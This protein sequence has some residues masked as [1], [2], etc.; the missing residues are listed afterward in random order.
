VLILSMHAEDQYALRVLRENAS[1]YLVKESVPDEVIRAI[2]KAARG[3]IYV[4]DA[5]AAGLVSERTSTLD[6]PA[7]EALSSREYEIFQ[8]LASGTPIKEIAFQLALA[9]TTVATYRSR[10]LKKLR[11]KSN[12]DLVRYA[13][14]HRLVS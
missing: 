3:E 13:L 9:R 8:R 12:S 6:A 1:G 5:L 7:H 10:I 14:R 11:I 2:R 4:S